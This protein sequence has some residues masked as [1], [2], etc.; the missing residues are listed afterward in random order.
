MISSDISKQCLRCDN[1]HALG[2]T[3]QLQSA[4]AEAA[5]ASKKKQRT[6]TWQYMMI[7]PIYFTS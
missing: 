7:L 4:G 2:E 5:T 3:V 1:T 6:I